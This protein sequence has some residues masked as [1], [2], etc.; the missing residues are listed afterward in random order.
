MSDERATMENTWVGLNVEDLHPFYYTAIPHFDNL[1]IPATDFIATDATGAQPA[2]VL[3]AGGTFYQVRE[4]I[5]NKGNQFG[6][7][8][9]FEPLAPHRTKVFFR[10]LNG[11][12][13][14]KQAQVLAQVAHSLAEYNERY[15]VLVE[16]AW[17]RCLRDNHNLVDRRYYFGRLGDHPKTQLK[18]KPSHVPT[19]SSFLETLDEIMKGARNPKT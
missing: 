16:M 13:G 15:R 5:T 14:G 9:T 1:T 2:V 17:Q 11:K 10:V 18:S 12:H 6:R 7:Q 4:D 3:T 8:M 19:E